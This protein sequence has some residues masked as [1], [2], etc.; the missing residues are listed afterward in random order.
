M[1]AMDRNGAADEG[2]CLIQSQSENI[3]RERGFSKEPRQ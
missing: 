3:L 2:A 1:L